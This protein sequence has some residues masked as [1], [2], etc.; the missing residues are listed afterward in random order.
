[1]DFLTHTRS[2][3]AGWK[4]NYYPT[5]ESCLTMRKNT[6]DSSYHERKSIVLKHLPLLLPTSPHLI[7]FQEE[8]SA[9]LVPRTLL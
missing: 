3:A 2:D 1:M 9:E 5:T 6:A 8:L 4:V 7:A